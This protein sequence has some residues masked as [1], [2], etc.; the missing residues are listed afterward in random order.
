[1]APITARTTKAPIET[2]RSS[3]ETSLVLLTTGATNAGLVF[4]TTVETGSGAADG[5]AADPSRLWR[6]MTGAKE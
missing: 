4:A 2:A 3:A 5:G 6:L 1:M